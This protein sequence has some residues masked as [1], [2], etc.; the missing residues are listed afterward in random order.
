NTYGLFMDLS[1]N[2]KPNTPKRYFIN[3]KLYEDWANVP[4]S[5]KIYLPPDPIPNPNDEKI[6][7]SF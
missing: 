6:R 4:K 3:G 5:Y 7:F 1:Y 2:E